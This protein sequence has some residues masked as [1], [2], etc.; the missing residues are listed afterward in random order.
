MFS[1]QPI[2]IAQTHLS[3]VRPL[4]F[5]SPSLA[6]SLSCYLFLSLFHFLPIASYLS[7]SVTL[8]LQDYCISLSIFLKS[9]C[10]CE[11]VL[12]CG[13]ILKR[14]RLSQHWALSQPGD[15]SL[16]SSVLIVGALLAKWNKI[17]Q[18]LPKAASCLGLTN[19]LSSYMISLP[20]KSHV[21]SHSS[22]LPFG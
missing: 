22:R 11:S 18:P 3:L 2:R 13:V 19:D 5:L 15:T 14:A 21:N 6:V 9:E 4:S 10:L 16:L 12:V 17:S 8:V 20:K 1:Q 7:T